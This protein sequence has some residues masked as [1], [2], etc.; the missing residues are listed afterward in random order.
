MEQAVLNLLKVTITEIFDCD[1]VNITPE[2]LVAN[3]CQK[4]ELALSPTGE[5]ELVEHLNKFLKYE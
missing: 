4:A 2:E 3:I 1:L 5:S